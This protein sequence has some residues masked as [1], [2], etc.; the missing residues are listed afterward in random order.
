MKKGKVGK[1]TTLGGN[2]PYL[3]DDYN[4]KKKLEQREREYHL[5]KV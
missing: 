5:S 4:M 3:E 1:M 2:I